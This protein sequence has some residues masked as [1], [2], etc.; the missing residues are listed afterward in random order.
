MKIIPNN[1]SYKF[2]DQN[3]LVLTLGEIEEKKKKKILVE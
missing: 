1:V 3:Q 2:D